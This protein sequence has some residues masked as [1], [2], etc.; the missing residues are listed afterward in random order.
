MSYNSSVGTN[1]AT[2]RPTKSFGIATAIWLLLLVLA[3]ATG[4]FAVWLVLFALFLILTTVYSFIFGRRSWL[5]LPHRKGAAAAIGGSVVVFVLGALILPPAETVPAEVASLA[6]AAALAARTPTQTPS[7][8][9]SPTP[10]PVSVLLTE[11]A[12]DGESMLEQDETL[13]CVADDKG[14]LVWMLEKKAKALLVKR[15]E[16]ERIADEK[17]SVE[18][19]AKVRAE[20]DKTSAEKA[21]AA[22]AAADKVAAEK[23]ATAKAAAEKAA[24][25]AAAEDAARVAAEQA[26]QQPAPA[27]APVVPAAVYY[28]NCAAARAA[29]ASPL[30]VGQPGYRGGL[31]RDKDGVACE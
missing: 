10:T 4:G 8:S 21:A 11:C 23:A 9:P 28:P 13:V 2:W 25:K 19:A 12:E 5:G 15:A 18:Y 1:K 16:V 22:K 31:D 30:F 27:P 29:G 14:V 20:A 6:D 17:A 7:P 26:A 24:E 3:L